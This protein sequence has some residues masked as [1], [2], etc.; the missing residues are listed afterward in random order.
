MTKTNNTVSVIPTTA[1]NGALGMEFYFADKPDS[2][3]TTELKKLGMHFSAK[4]VK[5]PRW[6]CVGEV[7][8]KAAEY[9]K[10]EGFDTTCKKSDLKA[11]NERLSQTAPKSTTKAAPKA[12]TKTTA[13]ATTKATPKEQ[14]VEDRLAKLES[15][16]DKLMT[17][18]EKIASK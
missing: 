8:P 13:K 1:N 18:L 15:N 17:M 5:G 3:V 14:S 12:T 16:M 11:V 7:I 6:Y 4:G 10:A 2:S 9:L